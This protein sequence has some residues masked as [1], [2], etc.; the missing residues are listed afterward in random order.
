VRQVRQERKI[1]R[2]EQ[3]MPYDETAKVPGIPTDLRE[4]LKYQAEQMQGN[5]GCQQEPT[6]GARAALLMHIDEALDIHVRAMADLRNVRRIV[7][8]Q[9]EHVC[10]II[11]KLSKLRG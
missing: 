7:S 9:P 2:E 4:K 10:E 8:C 3:E 6:Y 11:S 5:A 1:V